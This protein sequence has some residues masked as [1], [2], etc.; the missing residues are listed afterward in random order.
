MHFPQEKLKSLIIRRIIASPSRNQE[1][2]TMQPNQADAAPLLAHKHSAENK[3]F[4]H[5]DYVKT[6]R[7]Q[8]QNTINHVRMV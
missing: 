3:R 8:S 2:K 7:F 4:S 1:L 5:A 6:T